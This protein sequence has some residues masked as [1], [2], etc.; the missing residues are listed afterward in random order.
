[1]S[2]RVL[3]NPASPESAG[4]AA[5]V[6]YL[7]VGGLLE[8][9]WWI[10]PVV[11][12]GFARARF[13]RCSRALNAEPGMHVAMACANSPQYSCRVRSLRRGSVWRGVDCRVPSCRLR[14]P[15]SGLSIRMGRCR[16][17][18]FAA[19]CRRRS[20]SGRGRGSGRVSVRM[21][22]SSRRT[23]GRGRG[24][25]QRVDF[26]PETPNRPG[27]H[28]AMRRWGRRRSMDRYR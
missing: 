13:S 24:R 28:N 20:T 26:C 5:V 21:F 9:G 8:P 1:V 4:R 6:D 22:G 14:T 16:G 12:E 15:S 3:P 11:G 27:S 2:E 25:A 7:N 23:S 18:R 10:A 17:A 19:G